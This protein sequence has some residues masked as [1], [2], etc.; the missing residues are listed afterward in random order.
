[1]PALKYYDVGSGAWVTLKGAKGDT[2]PQGPPAPAIALVTSL[3]GSPSDG[4][5]VYYQAT[6]GDGTSSVIW[7]LRYRAGSSQ[8]YKWEFVGG[9]KLVVERAVNIGAASGSAYTTYDTG[10]ALALPLAGVYDIEV[11]SQS[12]QVENVGNQGWISYQIGATAAVDTDGITTRATA[13]A[14]NDWHSL[15]MQR[16]KTITSPLTLTM[17]IR[18]NGGIFYPTG[19]G[20][21]PR[22]LRATPV[23][24]G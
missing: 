14:A 10:P 24:V 2:G 16:R 3:P 12:A 21:N 9:G 20:A 7:H 6:D 15:T 22:G 13:T 11:Y 19:N 4:Q 23:R 18:V 17:Q 8:P 5:E 1:M